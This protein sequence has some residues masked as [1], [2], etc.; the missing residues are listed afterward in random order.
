MI[1]PTAELYTAGIAH[2]LPLLVMFMGTLVLG[3]LIGH[4]FRPV[5]KDTS[6][7]LQLEIGALKRELEDLRE[8][9]FVAAGLMAQRAAIR[10]EEF[11]E[12]RKRTKQETAALNAQTNALKVAVAAARRP[13]P[14]EEPSARDKARVASLEKVAARVPALL[15]ELAALRELVANEESA[16]TLPQP[17]P[18]RPKAANDLKMVDG[19]G[20][21]IAE[22]LNKHGLRTWGD[23]ARAKPEELKK[24]LRE[25]GDR[26]HMHDPSSWP[27]QCRLMV[28]DRWE[29]LHKYQQ[30]LQRVRASRS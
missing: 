8:K 27:K 15:K 16:R 18:L 25:A 4:A 19:I 1:N 28:E 23:V 10:E 9:N 21:K 30:G 12:E 11:A 22:H 6:A 20:P 26:F 17:K 24:V 5:H 2:L 29:E 13:L 14:P 7:P 3:T